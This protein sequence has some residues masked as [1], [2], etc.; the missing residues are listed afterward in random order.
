MNHAIPVLVVHGVAN[1]DEQLFQ[2]RV[3]RLQDE[4]G[5]QFL[6]IPVWWG[7]YGAT[8]QL[9]NDTIPTPDS[10]IDVVDQSG[11]ETRSGDAALET[12]LS[13]ATE[14]PKGSFEVR[15]QISDDEALVRSDITEQW[16]EFTSIESDW[17]PAE[18]EAIGR[19]IR[20]SVDDL[21]EGKD[22]YEV[23]AGGS[24]LNLTRSVLRGLREAWATFKGRVAG[25][26]HQDLRLKFL[27][28]L[29]QF[30]GDVFVYQRD[31]LAIQAH[32]WKAVQQHA[33]GYGV[34]EK[35]IA[36]IGHSLGGVI[37]FDA[38]VMGEPRLWIRTLVT[39]GSQP[40]FFHVIDPRGAPNVLPAYTGNAKVPLPT[41]IGKWV[42]IW[43]PLDPFAFIAERVF[44]GQVVDKTLPH[45]SKSRWY[46]HSDYWEHP[47][48]AAELKAAL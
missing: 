7:T 9:V 20:T 3:K 28:S 37:S 47:S 31:R 29:S 12:V 19:A 16:Q 18:L 5:D 4:L 44:T 21:D 34:K 24:R 14:R 27:P 38:A 45:D 43:E 13:V 40:A 25:D 15:T 23:R 35:P 26:I 30:L 6:L 11:H 17:T 36:V 10:F 1:R 32:L 8:E 41:T 48:I 39:L 42:N 22:E 46:T 33:P 2:E